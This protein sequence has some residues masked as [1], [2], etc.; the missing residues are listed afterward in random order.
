M[1]ES[2]RLNQSNLTISKHSKDNLSQNTFNTITNLQHKNNN[3]KT[4]KSTNSND[5]KF[6]NRPKQ[7]ENQTNSNE[8]KNFVNQITDAIKIEIYNKGGLGKN[9]YRLNQKIKFESFYAFL[10]S[11][12]STIDLLYVLDKNVAPPEGLNDKTKE[13]HRL[14]VRNILINRV[15]EI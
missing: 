11:E 3:D 13:K 6:S 12:L 5:S 2:Q 14:I 1:S 15:D 8:R 10:T 9:E 4:Q 7:K